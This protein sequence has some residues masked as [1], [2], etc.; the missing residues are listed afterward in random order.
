MIVVDT[1][2]VSE[3]LRPNPDPRV[4]AWL[5]EHSNDLAL[6]TITIGELQY[7][8]DRL[9]RGA[10]RDRLADA[11][12]ALV[13]TAADRVLDYD[14]P[15]AREYGRLRANR[16]R[17]GRVVSVEDTMIAAICL[18]GGHAVATRNVRDFADAGIIVHSPWEAAV[19]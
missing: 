16:E 1:N 8:V 7:G 11:V 19:G 3:P 14:A 13:V 17:A 5:A 12:A 15:S 9:P 10:R 18:T 2:V 4:V 6:T